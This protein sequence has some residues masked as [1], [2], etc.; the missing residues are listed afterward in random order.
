[1]AGH[2]MI[3]KGAT[4]ISNSWFEKG[5]AIGKAGSIYTEGVIPLVIT[6][7]TFKN[8]K[9]TSV[10]ILNMVEINNNPVILS[11]IIFDGNVADSS[12]CMVAND[13]NITISNLTMINNIANSNN[14]VEMFSTYLVS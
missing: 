3:K 11:N 10:G 7:V 8:C 1:M 13:I 5:S 4:Y 14:L 6:N 12:A 9:S 2:F